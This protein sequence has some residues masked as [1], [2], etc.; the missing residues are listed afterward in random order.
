MPRNLKNKKIKQ[1]RYRRN[2]KLT[3][4]G[5]KRKLAFLLIGFLV[6]LA[7]LWTV[8]FLIYQGLGRSDFFQITAIKIQG[9]RRT[10]KS[11]VLELS[12]VDIHTNLMALSPGK[13]KARLE[14]HEW[15]DRV[16]VDRNWPNRLTIS[17]RERV[18][19]AIV[20]HGDG[21]Y[22]LDRRGVKFAKV[23]AADDMDFPVITGFEKEPWPENVKDVNLGEALLFIR[24]ASRGSSIL[25]AQ[26][27]SELN[28]KDPQ[29]IVLF[30]ANRPFPV[31]LGT[32]K[33]GTKYYRLSKV[34]YWLYKKHEF[35]NTAYID[36]DYMKNR[37]LVGTL[38]A[39]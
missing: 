16:E 15:I 2:R 35:A 12:G 3:M 11:K 19:V 30:L 6:V 36:M 39:G 26:N 20:N 7:G 28:V 24:Y 1:Y 33:M 21:L 13:V 5:I 34:L 32:G 25:P 14:K 27:I 31:K 37:V 22:Y 23:Q 17:L 38:N 8:G 4:P 29:N 9:C 18:P 10:T